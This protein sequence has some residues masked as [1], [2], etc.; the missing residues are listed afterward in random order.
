M[1]DVQYR[2]D[3][4]KGLGELFSSDG[5]RSHY[6]SCGVEKMEYDETRDVVNVYYRSG[7]KTAVNVN[8]DSLAAIALDV[9]QNALL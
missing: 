1:R 2:K 7:G 5:A 6:E 8:M 4:V 3:F 9:V